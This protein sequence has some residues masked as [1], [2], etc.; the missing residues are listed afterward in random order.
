LRNR[1]G[2]TGAAS[3]AAMTSGASN[4]TR[5]ATVVSPI[6]STGAGNPAIYHVVLIEAGGASDQLLIGRGSLQ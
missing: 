5:C 4:R 6:W 1:V 2:T 3:S